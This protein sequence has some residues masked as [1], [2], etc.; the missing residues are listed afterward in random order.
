[1]CGSFSG[2]DSTDGNHMMIIQMLNPCLL[3]Q[4]EV[5]SCKNPDQLPEFEKTPITKNLR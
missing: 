5:V 1:M 4:Q 2:D 3:A